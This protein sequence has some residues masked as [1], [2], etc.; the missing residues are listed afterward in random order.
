MAAAI[1][2]D[3]RKPIYYIGS[4]IA[5]LIMFF[6]GKVVPTWGEVT[7]VGV[8]V[9]GVFLG[10][11]VAILFTGD[12]L[13]PSIVAMAALAVNGYY[14]SIGSAV[15]SIFGSTM[16]WGFFLITA[17]ISGMNELG[18]GEAIAA[19]ILTRKFVQKKPAVLS[20]VFLMAFSIAVNFG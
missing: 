5:I 9:I 3:N 20:Y 18:T 16:V 19:W 2:Q 4:V 17:V 12:T 7:E 6:F 13:W 1:K 14:P 8:S 15:G 10:I 11:M